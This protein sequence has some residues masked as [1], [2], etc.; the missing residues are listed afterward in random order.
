MPDVWD[1]GITNFTG[2]LVSVLVP[3][4]HGVRG[5]AVGEML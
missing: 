5:W 1:L 3:A 2:I 4:G